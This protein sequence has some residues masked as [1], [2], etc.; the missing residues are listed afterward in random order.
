MGVRAHEP[1]TTL[2]IPAFS[3]APRE[4]LSCAQHRHTGSSSPS[5]TWALPARAAQPRGLSPSLG[6]ALSPVL[7]QNG[8]LA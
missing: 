2:V 4:A 7:P 3:W 6:V 1:Y 8:Y 5:G